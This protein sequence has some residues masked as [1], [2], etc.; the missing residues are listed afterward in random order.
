M[1]DV[2]GIGY[3]FSQPE[4]LN[5]V[6]IEIAR[7]PKKITEMKKNC[8]VKAGEYLPQNALGVLWDELF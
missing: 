4:R 3:P 5:D 8:L 1:Q 2:T 6:L 7:D